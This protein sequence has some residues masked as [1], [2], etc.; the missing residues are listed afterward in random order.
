MNLWKLRTHPQS[1]NATSVGFVNVHSSAVNDHKNIL[2]TVLFHMFHLG[3]RNDQ[4]FTRFSRWEGCVHKL[5]AI[6]SNFCYLNNIPAIEVELYN[7][8]K[9][10]LREHFGVSIIWSCDLTF[11]QQT[12]FQWAFHR[13]LEVFISLKRLRR[14]QNKLARNSWSFVNFQFMYSRKPQG[15]IYINSIDFATLTN[16]TSVTLTKQ[17]IRRR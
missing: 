10:L 9:K 3:P 16:A 17:L 14:Q 13:T 6:F 15:F 7:F 8:W 5:L 11:L 12:C 2:R 4:H 1:Y